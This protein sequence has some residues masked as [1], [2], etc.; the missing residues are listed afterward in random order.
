M[1]VSKPLSLMK[2]RRGFTLIEL[3]VVISIIAILVALLLPAVQAARE[4]ARSTQCK[5]NLRQIGLAMHVFAGKD[6]STR[7]STGQWD[8]LRDGLMDKHGWVADVVELKAGKP[9]QMKCPTNPV[10]GSEK[11]NDANGDKNTSNGIRL[12]ANPDS[13]KFNVSD[14]YLFDGASLTVPI[15]PKDSTSTL[16]LATQKMVN[17]LGMNTNY[18]S[19]WHMSRSGVKFATNT[20]ATGSPYLDVIGAST[21]Y[22]NTWA[23]T[24]TVSIKGFKEVNNTTGPLT[25][26]MVEV[27]DVPSNNIPMLG[28]SAAGD[29]DEA[30]LVTT[31]NRELVAGSRLGEAANDGPAYWT[32]TKV[33][34]IEVTDAASQYLP[35]K[36]PIIGQLVNS[37]NEVTFAGT[38]ATGTLVGKLILQ[39]TRDWQAIH[40][41]KANILMADGSVKELRDLNGDTFFNPGFPV[42]GATPQTDGYADGVCEIN[43]FEV[44]TGTFLNFKSLTKGKFE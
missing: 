19:S 35:A 40:S 3:L 15:L 26:R 18:A 10:R 34:L 11:L 32:G 25:Q 6:P 39:D 22:A 33:Q 12:A 20:P 7:L 27:S 24:G 31:I 13:S 41:G 21:L 5:S 17:E 23:G 28:D 8:M 38:G 1:K 30:V 2:A 43:P 36:F 37:T 4:A 14:L 42:S 9:D 29:I 44:Y 16:K